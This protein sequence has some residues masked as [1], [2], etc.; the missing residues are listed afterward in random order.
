MNTHT[1][2]NIVRVCE[3]VWNNN[4]VPLFLKTARKPC[5]HQCPQPLVVTAPIHHVISHQT[6]YFLC[7]HTLFLEILSTVLSYFLLHYCTEKE[8]EAEGI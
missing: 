2:T 7:L 8:T 6:Q 1:Q 5:K 3:T 4:P